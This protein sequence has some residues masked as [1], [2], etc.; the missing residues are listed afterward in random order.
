VKKVER[1][2]RHPTAMAIT[3]GTPKLGGLLRLTWMNAGDIAAAWFAAI[4]GPVEPHRHADV[5]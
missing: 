1:F 5:E 4:D 2:A 3:L